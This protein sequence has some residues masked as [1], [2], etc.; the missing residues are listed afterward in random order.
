M[1]HHGCENNIDDE[2]CKL[3]TAD[4]YVFC[5]N[6]E[7]E[8]PDRDVVELIAKSR[9]VPKFMGTNQQVTNDFKFWFNSSSAETEREKNKAH[10]KKIEG[11]VASLAQKSGGQLSSF[12]LKGKPSFT[13]AL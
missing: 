12:F 1:Q 3:V 5:G 8:N 13:L 9:F 11:L 4:H 6:G 2:F 10:M 7:H